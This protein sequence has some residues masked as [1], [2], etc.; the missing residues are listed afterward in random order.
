M[1]ILSNIAQF[2]MCD[3]LFVTMAPPMLLSCSTFFRHHSVDNS[4]GLISITTAQLVVELFD[5]LIF[6][7]MKNGELQMVLGNDCDVKVEDGCYYLSVFK[8][9][10]QSINMPCSQCQAKSASGTSAGIMQEC[11]PPARLLCLPVATIHSSPYSDTA[12]ESSNSSTVQCIMS[13]ARTF[14]LE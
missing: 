4:R 2:K 5:I 9:L 10:K 14:K 1:D 6:S 13:Y 12:P 11:C 3:T 7:M 8:T